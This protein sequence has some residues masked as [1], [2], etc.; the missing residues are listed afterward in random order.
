[1]RVRIASST[2]KPLCPSFRCRTPGVMPIAFSARKPPTPSSSSWRMRIR[3]VAAVQ[4][5]VSSRVFRRVAFHVGVEQQ[6]IAAADFHA[7]DFGL[8]RAAA[9]LDL[10]RDRLAIGAD[11]RFHRQFVDVG[12][13]ILFLLPAVVIEPL[14][15]VTLTVKQADADQ[16]DIEIRGAL[17]VIAGEHAESAGIDRN[18]FVQAELGGKIGD[19]ARPQHAGVGRPPGAIRLEIFLLAPVGVIDPAVQHQFAGAPLDLR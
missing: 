12:L 14:A 3:A 16:R 18:R 4:A 8:D 11:R 17:D 15:E 9:R 1:M 2:A 10:H 13:E 19:R 6:Q 5:R 7:P